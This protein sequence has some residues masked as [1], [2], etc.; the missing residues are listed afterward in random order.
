MVRLGRNR[1]GGSSETELLGEKLG[2]PGGVLGGGDRGEMERSHWRL[3]GHG[4]CEKSKPPSCAINAGVT[5]Q[6]RS[7]RRGL[8]EDDGWESGSRLSVRESA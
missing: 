8:V 5:S 3:K 1:Q 2:R 7:G 4:H 6:Q